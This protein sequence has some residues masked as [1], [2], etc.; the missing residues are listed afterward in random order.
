MNRIPEAM[1][2]LVVP[3]ADLKHYRRN[4]RRGDVDAI[5][6]SLQAHGQY[7]PVVVNRRTG[8]V[9]AG[10]HTLRAARQLG[11]D[12]IAATYVDVDDDEAARIVLVD[13]RTND[14]AAYD[15]SE[16]VALL[17]DLPDLDGTGYDEDAL[18]DL[19]AGLAEPGEIAGDPDAAPPT[20]EVAR[21]VDGDVWQLGEH[22]L[23]VGSCTE[24]DVL[25]RLLGDERPDAVWTDP[26]YGVDYVGKTAEALTIQGDGA[27]GL[28]A[29]LR[30]AFGL[31]VPLLRP[32]APMYVAHADSERVTF[33][34]ALRDAAVLVR[35]NLVWVKNTMVLGRSDYHYQH[36][37][38]LYGFT[39]GGKGRLGRGGKRWHGDN[40]QTTVFH[41]DKPAA[42]NDH[43]TMK[44][45]ELIRAMLDNS[46]RP[47][48]LV[49][50]PFAGSG[51]TLIA[52]H[53]LGLRA[54]LVELDPRYAD[55]ICRRYQ[56]ATGD[57]PVAET[58][59]EPHDFLA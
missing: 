3:V 28:P 25:D 45:V 22:R 18:A 14:I 31:V 52:A 4:P 54:R 38:V 30:D 44:P 34:T 47:G 50:D 55:V 9:L 56:E 24:A 11:W 58:T 12:K 21:S 46:A 48:D 40:S 15:D 16:L 7:R 51:S 13:N 53:T 8:E 26:P 23:V 36:E 39:P 27:D 10:N 5:A 2:Q 29:L 32:G 59:G 20:P 57:K 41:V 43:P 33:E 42:S 49:L 6:D 19:V 17:E 37:P 1:A 35:Q